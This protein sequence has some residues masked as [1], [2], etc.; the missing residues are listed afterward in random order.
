M[1]KPGDRVGAILE[2]DSEIVYL[3]G[4]GV[5]DGDFDHPDWGFLNPRITLDDGRVVWGCEC[6]WASEKQIKEFIV[7]LKVVIVPVREKDRGRL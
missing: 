7:D 4:Y 1:T 6:W 5:Y 3:I 2:A